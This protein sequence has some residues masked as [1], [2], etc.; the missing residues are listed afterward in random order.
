[1]GGNIRALVASLKATQARLVLVRRH[2][3]PARLRIV[4]SS[5]PLPNSGSLTGDRSRSDG[6]R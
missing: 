5:E 3:E 2:L 1:M 6:W 4:R